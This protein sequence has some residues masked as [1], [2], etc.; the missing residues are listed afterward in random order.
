ME[1]D[2]TT[3]GS[4][5]EPR[6]IDSVPMPLGTDYAG[7]TCSLARTLEVVGERWTLLI[8]RDLFF[9]VRRFTDLQRHLDIPRAVLAS[10]LAALVEAGIVEP[11]P[12]RLTPAGEELWPAVFALMQWGERHQSPG[13]PRR[14][15]THVGCDSELDAGGR[16]PSCGSVP[17]ADALVMRPGPGA[18]AP[19]RDDAVTLALREP[20]RLLAEL[21]PARAEE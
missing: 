11:G 20:R 16:C 5:I 10:R 19:L 17:R 1:P 18:T 2:P 3:V 6:V 9:G 15:F 14:V 7:Q 12:Y 13:G 8:V 4:T 21:L